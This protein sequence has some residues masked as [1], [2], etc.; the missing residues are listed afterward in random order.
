MPWNVLQSMSSACQMDGKQGCNGACVSRTRASRANRQLLVAMTAALLG[1]GPSALVLCPGIPRAGTHPRSLRCSCGEAFEDRELPPWKNQVP[2]AERQQSLQLHFEH[3]MRGVA[4]TSTWK[5]M[6]PRQYIDEL[7]R[8]VEASHPDDTEERIS[9]RCHRQ[10]R[11]LGRAMDLGW[12]L[13]LLGVEDEEAASSLASENLDIAAVLHRLETLGEQKRATYRAIKAGDRLGASNIGKFHDR[14][15]IPNSNT[16][17]EEYNAAIANQASTLW[18]IKAMS[19]IRS[20]LR[21]RG[22]ERL[23]DIGSGCN[24]LGKECCSTLNW[25]INLHVKWYICVRI[26]AR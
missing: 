13:Q 11:K 2:K 26:H 7:E 6:D 19:L 22:V 3:L 8:R 23:L 17:V 15:D 24:V 14:S 18:H 21:E 4:R 12:E 5:Q 1:A 20:A 9:K 10:L 25:C 16:T